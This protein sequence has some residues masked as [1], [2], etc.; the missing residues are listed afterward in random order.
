MGRG[1]GWGEEDGET[2][3]MAGRGRRW[4]EDDDGAAHTDHP[5]L[6]RRGGP[7]SLFLLQHA[8]T[9]ATHLSS[10]V[11][12]LHPPSASLHSMQALPTHCSSF[13]GDMLTCPSCFNSKHRVHPY[14][15]PT[16]PF[17]R[18]S[19]DM[20]VPA[21]HASFTIRMP[22]SPTPPS[23]CAHPAHYPSS[24]NSECSHQRRLLLPLHL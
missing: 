22:G 19:F 10:D 23:T 15:T 8:C 18:P 4:G 5:D 24:F 20:R 17:T 9:P 11:V 16:S 2:R 1:G 13:D 6:L 12:M 14:H 21:T 7:C 3:K